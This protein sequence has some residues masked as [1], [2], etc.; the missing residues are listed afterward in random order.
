MHPY[1]MQR[2]LRERHKDELL[3]LKR[4]SL[5]HAIN[6]LA[7]AGFIE[8]VGT[9]R[10]GRRPQ[11][12]TYR[13]TA[14]G[15]QELRRSLHSMVASTQREP[16]EF[17]AALSFLVYL[18]PQ[19]AIQQLEQ[20]AERLA[21]DIKTMAAAHAQ[22][23]PRV[24][25]INLLEE[26]YMLGMLRAERRWIADFVEELRAGRFTWDPEL[27]LEGARAARRQLPAPKA[28]KGKR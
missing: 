19:E 21:A 26:E 3:A 2:L 10:Q 7:A 13:I 12:T 1:E 24:S 15:A 9:G 5:Y 27:V 25:R 18:P 11:R 4:G 28:R 22:L 8:S 16:T 14:N 6:R 20:R 23:L 17:F